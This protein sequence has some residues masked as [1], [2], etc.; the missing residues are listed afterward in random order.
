M[1]ILLCRTSVFLTGRK[2]VKRPATDLLRLIVF[3]VGQKQSVL[4]VLT[5]N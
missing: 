1:A 5:A 4:A 2:L 3:F